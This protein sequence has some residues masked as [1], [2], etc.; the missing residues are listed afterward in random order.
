MW[1]MMSMNQSRICTAEVFSILIIWEFLVFTKNLEV[2]VEGNDRCS[3]HCGDDKGEQCEKIERIHVGRV[4]GRGSHWTA[5]SGKIV[6][7]NGFYS[8]PRGSDWMKP[9]EN[10][11]AYSKDL[12]I[13]KENFKNSLYIRITN[14]AYSKYI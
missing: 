13:K 10:S 6:S 1:L 3:S 7:P 9:S 11:L 12:S 8:M 4:N 2:E 5:A 14:Y